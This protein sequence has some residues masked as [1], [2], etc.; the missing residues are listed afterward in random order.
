M[1]KRIRRVDCSKVQP[2]KKKYYPDMSVGGMY[3]ILP[4]INSY[5][6]V[7]CTK[8]GHQW[9]KKNKVNMEKLVASIISHE[10]LHKVLHKTISEKASSYLDNIVDYNKPIWSGG[11]NKW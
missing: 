9:I 4:L 6:C 11:I 2:L 8:S 3:Y 5:I 10:T 7:R 1:F